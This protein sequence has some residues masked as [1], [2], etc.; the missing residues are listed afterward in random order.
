[1]IWTALSPNPPPLPND[2]E[3]T[4]PLRSL[5]LDCAATTAI[6]ALEATRL[7]PFTPG[8][9]ADTVVRR[10]AETLFEVSA[11]AD[12]ILVGVQEISEMR[13]ALHLAICGAPKLY[14]GSGQSHFLDWAL[15]LRHAI[16]HPDHQAFA[17]RHVGAV[18]A[19]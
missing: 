5:Y 8:N 11:G 15:Q 14:E 16:E 19:I 7:V 4:V 3:Q 18:G 12:R 10:A 9:L 17:V 2:D 1:M 6:A 13:T